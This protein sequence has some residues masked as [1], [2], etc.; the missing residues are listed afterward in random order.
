MSVQLPLR[1]KR[2]LFMLFG[3]VSVA[4]RVLHGVRLSFSCSVSFH[5]F[6]S[7]HRVRLTFRCR[8][9]PSPIVAKR[10]LA[11]RE[12]SN[13]SDLNITKYHDFYPRTREAR[14]VKFLSSVKHP[15]RNN[16]K[17]HYLCTMR[18]YNVTIAW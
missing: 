13:G 4:E 7:H 10:T 14:F 5:K 17:Y 1:I 18:L 8:V 9:S 6:T 3:L 15:S 12:S 11:P 2:V 16:T